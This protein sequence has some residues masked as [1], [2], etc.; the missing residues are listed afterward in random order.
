M[1]IGHQPQF[2][3]GGDIVRLDC[4]GI[5]CMQSDFDLVSSTTNLTKLDFF[6]NIETITDT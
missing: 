4:V 1:I 3:S 5:D 6:Y 2:G